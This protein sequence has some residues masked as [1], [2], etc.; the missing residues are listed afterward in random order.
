MRG[1]IAP[2]DSDV[3]QIRRRQAEPARELAK[4]VEPAAAC[5]ILNLPTPQNSNANRMKPVL[6][7]II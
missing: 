2:N 4:S 5:L 1:I 3:L 7:A 6:L